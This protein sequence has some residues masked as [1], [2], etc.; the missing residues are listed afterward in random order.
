MTNITPLFPGQDPPDS[1][2]QHELDLE[3]VRK[4]CLACGGSLVDS[5]TY[6][7]YLVCPRCRFHYTMSARRRVEMLADA[8]TFR[9]TSRWIRS[10][11]PLSFSARVSYR[12]RLLQDQ[13]R[14]G[15]TEAVITGVCTIGGTPAILIVLDF[16]FLGGSMGLVVGEK[17]ALALQLAARKRYPAIA[18]INSGG[19]RIQEGILS[20]MQ[21]AKTTVAANE[22]HRRGVPLVSVLGDPATGQVYASFGTQADLIFAEPGAHVGFAPFRAIKEEMGGTTTTGQHTAEIHF[23]H[24]MLDGVVDRERIKHVVSTV[25]ELLRPEFR[26]AKRRR[27]RPP[28]TRPRRMEAWEMVQLARHPERPTARQFIDHVFANLV[29]LHGDRQYADAPEVITGI[30]RLAGQSVIV[31]GQNKTLPS[32]MISSSDDETL[33]GLSAS[34]SITPE[35]FGKAR[36]AVRFAARFNLPIVTLVD[37]PGSALDLEAWE[38]GQAHAISQT[39]STLLDV[40]VPTISVLIGEGGSEAALAFAVTDRV[41][42]LQNAIYTPISPERAAVAELRD[43]A[44]ADQVVGALRLTSIDS[45]RMGIIDE[46]VREPDGGAHTD[47][48][49]ASRLLKRALMI[50]ITEVVELHRRTLVRRRQRKYRNIGESGKPFRS[51]LRRELSVW[52]SA[53]SASVRALRSGSDPGGEAAAESDEG[54][55]GE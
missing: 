30:A 42:M 14:T 35:G 19:A 6:D 49:E 20:L 29:E 9:E 5:P 55:P 17:V 33:E 16:G 4:T 41:L 10:L 48:L 52:R 24:G 38:R 12:D 50:E 21:M 2:D 44:A 46:I 31:I 37:T 8:G 53:L 13:D 26:L 54:R 23:R 32:G 18:V 34:G 15:L 45:R 22:M 40:E 43:S 47:P 51:A 39:I 11:D 1:T 7:R 25:L 3:G 36:R 28:R 27:G